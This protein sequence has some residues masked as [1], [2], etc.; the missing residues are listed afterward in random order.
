MRPARLALQPSISPRLRTLLIWSRSMAALA[1]PAAPAAVRRSHC[2]DAPPIWKKASTSGPWKSSEVRA[3]PVGR[4]GFI[5]AGPEARASARDGD[6]LR[7][8]SRRVQR[9]GSVPPAGPWS[10]NRRGRTVRQRPRRPCQIA[11]LSRRWKKGSRYRWGGAPVR[12]GR[13]RRRDGRLSW[14]RCSTTSARDAS[15][16][17]REDESRDD[18]SEHRPVAS[19]PER[20]NPTRGGSACYSTSEQ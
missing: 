12:K 16:P 2:P 20:P 9:A 15:V 10:R 18:E 14:S 5:L 17:T 11:L 3:I 13:C 4:P 7:S 8:R 19:R 6:R 1:K